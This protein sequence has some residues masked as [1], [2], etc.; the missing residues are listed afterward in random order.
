MRSTAAAP[1]RR[2][3]AARFRGQSLVE[4]ALVL[5]IFLVMVM[6]IVDLGLSVF[7]Y[8]S[9]TNAAR[10]GAR[11]AIVNQDSTG[12]VARA[13]SQ[14]SVARSQTV[15]VAYYR[16][17]ADGTPDTASTCPLAT[18]TYIA[19]GC[20][21]VVTFQGTYAP[22]TPLIGNIVFKGGIT[23]SAKT[24]LPVE[25]SCPNSTQTAAQCPKQP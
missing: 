23:F 19:V 21:A 14:A 15:T 20:L 10:E 25:Y 13:K 16:A 9:I 1:R 24:V 12:V 22:I 11:L 2:G 6:A 3:R 8:N 7:A 17:N 4:F 18:S 5:P